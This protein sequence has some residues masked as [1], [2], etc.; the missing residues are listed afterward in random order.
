MEYIEGRDLHEYTLDR[1][2]LSEA[3]ALAYIDL[4]AQALDRVHQENFS[5]R[6]QKDA[7]GMGYGQQIEANLWRELVHVGVSER[8]QAAIQAGMEIEPTKRPQTMTEFRELLGLV[9][10]SVSA[11]PN[12]DAVDY[13]KRCFSKYELGQYEEAIADLDKAIEQVSGQRAGLGAVQ[14][15]LTSTIQNLQ[16]SGENLSTANSRIRDTD[17]ADETAKNV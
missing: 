17:F 9:S 14:N 8:T 13:F 1:G 12:L 11:I 3:E 10:K 15:R 16:V 7:H 5:S 2:R 6:C 4:I